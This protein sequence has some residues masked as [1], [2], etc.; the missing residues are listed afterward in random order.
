MYRWSE[1]EELDL[2][3]NYKRFGCINYHDAEIFFGRSWNSITNKASRMGLTHNNT[4]KSNCNIIT[5]CL[6]FVDGH[7]LGDAGVYPNHRR[8]TGTCYYTQ[9]CIYKEYVNDIAS[10]FSNFDVVSVVNDGRYVHGYTDSFQYAVNSCYYIEFSVIRS[11]WYSK[12]YYDDKDGY[13]YFKYQKIVPRD[14]KLSPV[15]VL[16]WYL[17]DGNI[18]YHSINISTQGFRLC[19]V[20]FLCCCLN[21]LLDLHARYYKDKKSEGYYIYIGKKNHVIDFLNYIKNCKIPNCYRYKFPDKLMS[22]I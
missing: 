13:E 8:F 18:N 15:C 7:L 3:N 19:D 11:R 5:D 6:N 17:D 16:N 12:Y 1:E 10:Y 21:D 14:I 4:M 9:S 20:D 22:D 2:I